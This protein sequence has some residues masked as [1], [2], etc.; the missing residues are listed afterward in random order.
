MKLFNNKIT[1]ILMLPIYLVVFIISGC[2]DLDFN[3]L[4][5]KNADNYQSNW[6]LRWDMSNDLIENHQVVG[7]DTSQIFNLL[8][9]SK[10][11]Y[12]NGIGRIEYS[13]GPC[14]AMN[15]GV[16]ILTIKKGVVSHKV[17]KP[18]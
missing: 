14:E 9:K 17:C 15:N 6:A 11:F 16:L 10:V 12:S 13:L 3:S 18:C 5:W 8:G 1:R 2:Q 7:K 4:K